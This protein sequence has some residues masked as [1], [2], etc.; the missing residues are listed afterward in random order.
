MK[1][2]LTFELAD[3]LG[4][5]FSDSLGIDFS[6]WQYFSFSKLKTLFPLLI[7]IVAIDKSVINLTLL[8]WR[9]S[10]V[11][12]CL[13][14]FWPF[15]VLCFYCN[16][17]RQEM[18]KRQLFVGDLLKFLNVF[19]FLEIFHSL[20]SHIASALFSPFLQELQLNIHYISHFVFHIS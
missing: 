14:F 20:S 15:V 11:S 4:L 9:W 10:L 13:R 7:S 6:D 8:F 5:D 12:L 2:K 16:V 17:F 1:V 3:S 19:Y 18:F